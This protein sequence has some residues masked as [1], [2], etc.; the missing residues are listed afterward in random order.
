MILFLYGIAIILILVI[1]L[2][3]KEVISKIIKQRRAN[4]K[5]SYMDM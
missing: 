3:V 2:K 1:V 4:G 5:E